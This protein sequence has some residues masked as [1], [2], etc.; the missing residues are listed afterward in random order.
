M[1]LSTAA[2]H[3]LRYLRGASGLGR[4]SLHAFRLLPGV[5]HAMDYCDRG[6]DRDHPQHGCHTIGERANNDQH[7]AFGS[8]HESHLAG[9]DERLGTGARVAHH[10]STDHDECGQHDVKETVAA[11]VENEEPKEQSGVAVTVED[12]IKEGAEAG[13]LIARTRY[14]TVN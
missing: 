11:G 1:E 14:R 7:E 12:G 5:V 10:H 3:D 9:P 4:R 13:H 2:E 6:E 8:L